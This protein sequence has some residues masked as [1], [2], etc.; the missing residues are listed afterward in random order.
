LIPGLST[1][2]VRVIGAVSAA[3]VKNSGLVKVDR[4]F[5]DLG[6]KHWMRL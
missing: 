1:C 3:L 5:N 4:N 2:S 6:G